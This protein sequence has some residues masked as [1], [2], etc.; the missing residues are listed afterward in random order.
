MK[1]TCLGLFIVV[2][3]LYSC[4]S[5]TKTDTVDAS[6]STNINSNAPSTEP[7]TQSPSDIDASANIPVNADHSSAT[8]T[9]NPVAVAAG[10]NPAHGQPGH[11]CDIS[12]G[13]PL[14]SAPS[15]PAVAPQG[16]GTPLNTQTISTAPTMISAPEAQ[17]PASSVPVST[18]PGM[19]P[20]HGQ[21]GHDC[22]IAV[23]APLKK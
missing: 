22:A 17:P 23:G 19:N 7:V 4:N 9:Q 14:S 20:P 1:N 6:D 10:M 12:V 11:R 21:P 3:F 18:A 16:T 8:A 2:A 13:A 5:E 15:T